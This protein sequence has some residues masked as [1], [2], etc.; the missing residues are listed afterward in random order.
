MKTLLNPAA[1]PKPSGYS[2]G[3]LTRGGAVVF[4]AGQ[5]A[6]NAEG[7]IAAP[8]DLVAQFR[9]AL[10]NLRTVLHEAGGSMTDLVKLT[11]YVTDKRAYQANRQA[12]GGVYREFFGKYYPAI[13]LVEVKGLWDD[14]ALL[15]IEGVAVIEDKA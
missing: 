3:V 8:G 2:H 1:L 5:T 7:A 12:I 11:L 6:M 15:E 13:T 14:A 9:L 10:E 4:L